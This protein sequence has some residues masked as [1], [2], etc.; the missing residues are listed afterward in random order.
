LS[1]QKAYPFRKRNPTEALNSAAKA[2]MRRRMPASTKAAHQ[3]NAELVMEQIDSDRQ[4]VR[5]DFR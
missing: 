1:L 2:R 5:S 3:A 4:L